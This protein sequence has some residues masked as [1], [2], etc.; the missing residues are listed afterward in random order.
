MGGRLGVGMLA[1]M[2]AASM[3]GF[4]NALP[5]IGGTTGPRLVSEVT[6]LD[7]MGNR[8]RIPQHPDHGKRHRKREA[9][10]L[11]KKVIAM[12]SNVPDP[13]HDKYLNSY[14]RTLRKKYPGQAASELFA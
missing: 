10:V 3:I 13:R 9:S 7:G 12:H 5:V 8:K 11:R 6:Y 1:S 2:L 14:A 4:D